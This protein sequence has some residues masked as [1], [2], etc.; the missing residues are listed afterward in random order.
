[1]FV[2]TE[3]FHVDR[4][5][6]SLQVTVTIVARAQRQLVMVLTEVAL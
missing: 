1:M 4:L 2:L 6:E 5:I 3:C